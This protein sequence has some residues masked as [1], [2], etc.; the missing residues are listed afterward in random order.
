ML[1]TA[2]GGDISLVCA[3]FALKSGRNVMVLRKQ[4]RRDG[5]AAFLLS[6]FVG[7]RVGFGMYLVSSCRDEITLYLL[8]AFVTTRPLEKAYRPL[9]GSCT[10][11][12]SSDEALHIAAADSGDSY[13]DSC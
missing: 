7:E 8:D 4:E 1:Q 12:V 3:P 2:E 10:L 13:R 5:V 11:C 9:E 6:K